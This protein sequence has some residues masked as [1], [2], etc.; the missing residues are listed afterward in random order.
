MGG[1]C[2]HH[3]SQTVSLSLSLCLSREKRAAFSFFLGFDSRVCVCDLDASVRH[4][5]SGAGGGSMDRRKKTNSARGPGPVGYERIDE[6][7]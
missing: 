7:D 4:E 2:K 6:M 1:G 5:V 3:L